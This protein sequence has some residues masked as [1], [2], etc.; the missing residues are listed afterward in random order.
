MYLGGGFVAGWLLFI[1]IFGAKEFGA[2]IS[3]TISLV[4]SKDMLDSYVFPKPRLFSTNPAAL[5]PVVLSMNILYLVYK[6]WTEYRFSKET[7]G[8][9]YIH[10]ILVVLSIAFVR[11]IFRSNEH[12][13]W[14]VMYASGMAYLTAGY[15]LCLMLQKSRQM[16]QKVYGSLIAL[17]VIAVILMWPNFAA[18]KGFPHRVKEFVSMDDNKF[19]QHPLANGERIRSSLQELKETFKDEKTIFCYTSEA[20]MPYLLKKLP[21][22]KFPIV[23]IAAAKKNRQYILD[24]LIKHPPQRI[25][26]SSKFWSNSIDEIPNNERFRELHGFITKQYSFEKLVNGEFEI[27]KRAEKE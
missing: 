16:I 23:W 12:D 11:S 10:S 24:M 9:A 20:A 2:F 15:S 5:M 8:T 14:H 1:I 17:S 18:T 6:W 25:L 7:R 3:N 19:L 27:Y 4:S 22:N 13:Q 26:F 21:H